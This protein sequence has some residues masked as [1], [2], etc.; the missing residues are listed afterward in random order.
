MVPLSSLGEHLQTVGDPIAPIDDQVIP[1]ARG[2]LWSCL[3]F[4]SGS[5]EETLDSEQA[6]GL[7]PSAFV[8]HETPHHEISKAMC[9]WR[10]M[11]SD[12]LTCDCLSQPLSADVGNVCLGV[13]QLAAHFTGG[14]I[15][16]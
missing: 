14:I 2:D 13:G 16:T 4:T 1:Q 8:I 15:F 7:C 11:V 5:Q 3:R 9:L 12:H 6:A 10:N